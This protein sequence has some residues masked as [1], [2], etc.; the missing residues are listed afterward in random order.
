MS[1]VEDLFESE[2]S[3]EFDQ[4]LHDFE[5]YIL[6]NKKKNKIENF[7]ESILIPKRWLEAFAGLR[8]SV[9]TPN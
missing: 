2:I 6:K 8:D 7:P 5:K 4:L 1:L 9:L 3:L